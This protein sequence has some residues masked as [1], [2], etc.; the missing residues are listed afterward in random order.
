MNVNVSCHFNLCFNNIIDESRVV[1][2]VE[3]EVAEA[4]IG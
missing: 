3:T 4:K 1:E 2:I